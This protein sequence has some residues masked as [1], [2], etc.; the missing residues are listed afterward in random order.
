MAYNWGWV[1]RVG[2]GGEGVLHRQATGQCWR[3]RGPIYTP[4]SELSPIYFAYTN[5]YR[6]MLFC[7]LGAIDRRTLARPAIHFKMANRAIFS[8][9]MS[10]KPGPH[11]VARHP[12]DPMLLLLV[13]H[14]LKHNAHLKLSLIHIWRER[15][16]LRL[17]DAEVLPISNK[18]VSSWGILWHPRSA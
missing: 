17:P 7:G 13:E 3:V 8:R 11:N 10:R 16:T 6:S 4:H 15:G 14:R 9:R 2:G 5:T 18:Q 1:A 12:I